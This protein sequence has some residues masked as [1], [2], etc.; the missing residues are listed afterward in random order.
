MVP[1]ILNIIFYL[2]FFAHIIIL[3]ICVYNYLTAPKLRNDNLIGN[4]EVPLSIL[5]P[6]RNEERNIKKCLD[7]VFR[8]TYQNF[9]LFVLDDIS[10]DKTLQILENY[11]SSNDRL[12]I[13]KGKPLP[14]GWLGKNW[15]CHQLAENST[16]DIMIFLDA[17]VILDP[18]ALKI[19]N[20]KF[21]NKNVDLLSVFPSQKIKTF[22]EW[23]IVPLMD[24]ML[25]SFLPLKKV[26]SSNRQSFA[27]ANGQFMMIKKES[28]IKFG[29]HSRVKDRVV[30]DMEFVRGFK[31][32]GYRT[33]TF[34]ANDFVKCRM[35][36]NFSE[37]VNGFI[38]NFYS[39]FNLS[40]AG[41]IGLLFLFAF[42]FI[43]P[44]VMSF[45]QI[46]YLIILALMIFERIISS[47]ISKQNMVINI[48]MFIPQLIMLQI[49]GYKSLIANKLKKI[50]WK[51]RTIN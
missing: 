30:E 19:V 47:L 39:G 14:N 40:S 43:I 32:M 17:D 37:A 29:G 33:V 48:L 3:S 50:T 7:S 42:I 38:K 44:V 20:E 16:N 45:I 12:N 8:S 21:I 22:G 34:S 15:A 10:A 25:Y 18:E 46:K 35:Y 36:N 5:I 26:Y 28:Y 9:E 51:N 41:F 24:W 27:A 31:K 1:D 13:I 23:L 11:K 2:I 49:L 6:A 4:D